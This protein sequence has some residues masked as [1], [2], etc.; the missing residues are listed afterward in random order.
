M[1]RA[2]T[3][4][5]LRADL[6]TALPASRA[7]AVRDAIACATTGCP[8][9]VRAGFVPLFLDPV[10]FLGTGVPVPAASLASR[11][12]AAYMVYVGAM[13]AR[14]TVDPS[15]LRPCGYRATLTWPVRVHRRSV[16]LT[17]TGL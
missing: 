16:Q 13:L 10:L 9:G 14:E 17:S 12:V 2:P 15:R 7:A 6:L 5:D 3:L 8:E 4:S 1:R 11:Y